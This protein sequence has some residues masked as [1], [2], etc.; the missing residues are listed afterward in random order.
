MIVK[1]FDCQIIIIKIHLFRSVISF[2]IIKTI[3]LLLHISQNNF[4]INHIV[5]FINVIQ[6]NV[7]NFLTATK[8]SFI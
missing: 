3:H 4:F 5:Y 1:L 8:V 7:T 6:W 2:P